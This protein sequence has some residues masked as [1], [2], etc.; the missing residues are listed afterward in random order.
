MSRTA[1]AHPG[2]TTL[3]ETID[4]RAKLYSLVAAAAGV[5][6]LALA[7]PADAEVIITNKI[8]PIPN[9][10]PAV[11]DACPVSLDLNGDGV[12]DLKFSIGTNFGA[13]G[14]VS[15]LQVKGLGANEVV[16][17]K[18]A[19]GGYASALMRSAKIG[20]SAHFG[21]ANDFYLMAEEG[22]SQSTCRPPT[23]EWV[24]NR[25]NRF[26]GIKF[27]IKGAI[28][29][30]WVRVTVKTTTTSGT[31]VTGTITE[32]GYE[33]I[34][35]KTVL[36]GL[37]STDVASDQASETKA[38]PSLGALALG[39]DGLNLWRREEASIH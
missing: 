28:H 32:Y 7:Q 31:Y 3:P 38:S 39:A 15:Y 17:K 4:R 33:T 34:A 12:A 10:E 5:S 20:P 14:G 29:Y 26:I 8:I 6:V 35:N 36:A 9:C 18:G 16:G 25:P 30:G 19:H 23:G 37:A 2:E 22:C 21:K 11:G 1:P 13:S 27:K 24:G